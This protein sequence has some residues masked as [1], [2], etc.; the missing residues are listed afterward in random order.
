MKSL[1]S[2]SGACQSGM[3]EEV[4]PHTTHRRIARTMRP[5]PC[6]AQLLEPGPMLAAPGGSGPLED[7]MEAV[8]R[9]S[10]V[11]AAILSE[12]LQHEW[13]VPG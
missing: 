5:P 9:A 2:D 11:P 12:Q 4:A 6:V 7:D 8:S 10:L 1:G 3:S 13:S